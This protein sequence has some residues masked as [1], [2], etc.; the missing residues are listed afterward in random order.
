MRY[1]NNLKYNSHTAT[2]FKQLEYLNI[3]DLISFN[4]AVF[5]RNYSNNKLPSSFINMFGPIPEN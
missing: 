1:I 4:Q 5:M 3:F 2:Y